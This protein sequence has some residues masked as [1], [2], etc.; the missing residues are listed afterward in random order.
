M[1]IYFV[2]AGRILYRT[3]E[4][5][6][7]FISGYFLASWIFSFIAVNG[8]YKI[9]ENGVTIA[10]I[11]NGVHTDIVVPVKNECR[12]WTKT[13]SYSAVKK[14][15]STYRYLSFGW[16]DKGFFI[17]TPTWADLKASTAINAMFWMSTSAM[18]V[19]WKKN[20]VPG[21]RC[22]IVTISKANYN[23][24]CEY[25]LQTFSLKA[26]QFPEH[27]KAPGYGYNDAFY[28]AKGTYNLFQTC[29]V[30]TG[31]GLR[32]AGVRV[33]LWTPFEKSVFRQL[34]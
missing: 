23:L 17:N 30:W 2:R 10:I 29:N 6:T 28:E 14:A 5:L 20:I 1:K 34:P 13:F 12:D 24:L 4:G 31:K 11:S 21:A 26:D 8:D 32:K 7:L 27:I 3:F 19:T 25:I 22:R 16:G 15:D 9:P 33:A 18:H